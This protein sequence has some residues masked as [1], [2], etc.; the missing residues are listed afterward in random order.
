MRSCCGNS[1]IRAVSRKVQHEP[2]THERP[3]RPHPERRRRPGPERQAIRISD[4]EPFRR[5]EP[6]S[7]PG[8]PARAPGR[9]RPPRDHH[10]GTARRGGLRRTGHARG[11]V[12]RT[13]RAGRDRPVPDP[14]GDPAELPRRPR[15]PRPGPHRFRQDPRLRAG[16][17]GPHGR[18]AG[19][20]PA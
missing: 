5:A 19:R 16:P 3:F 14:G 2:R 13:R 9:V 12:G 10:P 8:P 1:L 7:G 18:A 20:A 4:P 17:A 11:A 6:R 15:R